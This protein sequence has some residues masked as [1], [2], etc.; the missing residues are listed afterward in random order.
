MFVLVPGVLA[1]WPGLQSV[2]GVQL[3]AFDVVLYEST[4]AEQTRLFELV[5][6]VLTYWPAVQSVNGV[7]LSAFVVVL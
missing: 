7:Q 5:P 6:G 1:Y 4:H 3:S 2:N